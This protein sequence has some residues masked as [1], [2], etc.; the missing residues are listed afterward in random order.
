MTSTEQPLALEPDQHPTI[1][2]GYDAQR[3]LLLKLLSRRDVPAIEIMAD[4]IG[5]LTVSNLHPFSRGTV[6]ALSS[7]IF[8][9]GYVARNI[10]L[11]PRYCSQPEDCEVLV[12]ALRFNGRLVNTTS[13]QQLMPRPP[14]PW[15]ET[16]R[17]AV[18]GQGNN[19]TLLLE[20]IHAGLTTEFHA[21]GTTSMLPF[22]MGGVVDPH[23]MVYG[24]VNLRVVDAGIIPLIPAAHIQAAVYAVAEKVIMFYSLWLTLWPLLTAVSFIT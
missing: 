13:M 16:S 15:D 22:D 7:D 20:A 21:C 4:S 17:P 10:A 14:S 8:S 19:D 9:G 3:K 24:T 18:P 1:L 5:T 11:D 23:L 2:K 12:A 6:R